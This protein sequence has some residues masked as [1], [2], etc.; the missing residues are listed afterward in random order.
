MI[1]KMNNEGIELTFEQ[2]RLHRRRLLGLADIVPLTISYALDGHLDVR[3]FR[4]AVRRTVEIHIG[5]RLT[6]VNADSINALQ[7][8]NS[9]SEMSGEIRTQS[10]LCKS[11]AQFEAYAGALA[12]RDR[13]SPWDVARE[14][15]FR[16]RLLR[17]SDTSHILLGAFNHFF[18]DLTAV[19][20]FE[21][22]LWSHYV[23]Y[24][25]GIPPATAERPDLPMVIDR[26]AN[27]YGSLAES[28]NI[29][30]WRDR[31]SIAPPIWQCSH[32]VGRP[33]SS[34]PGYARFVIRYEGSI[35]SEF[36]L[37]CRARRCSL[38]QLMTSV[39]AWIGFQM[40]YQDR[41]AI[42][43]PID[44]RVTA[45]KSLVG[46]FTAVRAV[47]LGRSEGG[48]PLSY[49]HQVRIESL[50]A[51]SHLHVHGTDEIAETMRA[52]GRWHIEPQRAL[53]I[54]YIKGD[55][56]EQV[57]VSPDLTARSRYYEPAVPLNPGAL[58]LVVHQFSDSLKVTFDYNPNSFPQEVV[59]NIAHTFDESLRALVRSEHPV[60]P[61]HL[62]AG[63]AGSAPPSLTPLVDRE[64]VTCLHV[65]LA[66]VHDILLRHPDVRTAHLRVDWKPGTGSVLVADLRV[67]AVIPVDELRQFCL[68]W[69]TATI[70]AIAPGCF[71]QFVDGAQPSSAG[72]CHPGF[73]PLLDLLLDALPGAD[74]ESEFWSAGGTFSVIDSVIRR[75]GATAGLPALSY[76]HFNA[77]RTLTD[78]VASALSDSGSPSLGA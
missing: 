40:T 20:V 75:A 68:N 25:D 46:M 18:F 65:D 69:P 33:K 61:R 4:Q 24:L 7:Q 19:S 74:P 17:Y 15:P 5:T 26:R 42:Y 53:S 34:S 8:V 31:L 76:R 32:L 51:L 70:F 2:E 41:L 21:R 11:R 14:P 66:E 64:G 72:V 30:Y 22:D 62:P 78:I 23:H 55:A 27:D 54:N 13:E 48:G 35:M 73:R 58:V 12:R 36:R 50:E 10:V 57:R 37:A 63:Y 28:Q 6:I 38:L 49:L 44:S 29:A 59:R 56:T 16:I 47:V 3:A 43:L 67:R 39:L 77:P 60:S 1:D 52:W 45:E 71:N 9:S